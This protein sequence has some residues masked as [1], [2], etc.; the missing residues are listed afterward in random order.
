MNK[1]WLEEYLWVKDFYFLRKTP[2]IIM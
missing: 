1:Y 2:S